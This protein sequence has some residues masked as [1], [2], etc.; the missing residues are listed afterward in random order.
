MNDSRVVV[1]TGASGGVGRAVARTFGDRGDRVALL[2]RGEAGLEGALRDVEVAGG[3]G[4]AIPTDV[5]DPAAVEA[6]AERTERELGPIDVWVN[7][8]TATVFAPVHRI[9]PDEFR[10]ATE[11]TYLGA[12]WGTMAALSRM[13]SRDRGTIVQVGS[14][15]AYRAI[16]LQSAY[17]GAKHALR[18]FTDSLRTEL[19]HDKSR[20]RLTSVHLPALD[21]PQ[22]SWSR[23]KLANHPQPVPPIYDPDVAAKAI[24][25]ASEHDRREV[26]VGWPT[27]KTILGNKVAPGIADRVLARSGYAAQ[28]TDDPVDPDRKDNLF[29]P[30]DDTRDHGAH[31]IFGERSRGSSPALWATLHRG[32][33][34][35]GAALLVAG[36]FAV[37]RKPGR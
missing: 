32:W 7:D 15:L 2:A 11:V 21:T 27:Y 37:L 30:V 33:V 3:T 9:D 25:W 20:V 6:A 12:V 13:R 19:M 8:A 29:Q 5:A 18:G 1:V 24:V 16:P 14:A 35:A 26:W 36:G 4:I 34:A 28:Q 17:C 22:F 23:A 10:R 31:G